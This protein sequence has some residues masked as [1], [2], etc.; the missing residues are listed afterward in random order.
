MIAQPKI[1]ECEQNT[2][3]WLGERTKYMGSSDAPIALGYSSFKSPVDLA[4]EKKI[5]RTSNHHPEPETKQQ[6]RGH[7]LEPLTGEIYSMQTGALL[8]PGKSYIHPNGIMAASLDFETFDYTSIVE[9][10]THYSYQSGNYPESG[11]PDGVSNYE[12]I[13]C[14]HQ[15]YVAG[16]YEMDC[17]VLFGDEKTFDL[18]VKMLDEGAGVRNV[19]GMCLDIGM[20]FRIYPIIRNEALIETMVEMEIEFWNKYVLGDEIPCD[21]RYMEPVNGLRT[22]TD[23]EEK[24]IELLKTEWLIHS[25][26]KS[27]I[28]R[29]KDELKMSIKDSEGLESAHGKITYRKPKSNQKTNWQKAAERCF[30]S[31]TTSEREEILKECEEI[32]DLSRRLNLPVSMW[33]KDL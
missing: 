7:S 33:K 32:P 8:I 14:H 22:A 26:A 25:M 19:A 18:L 4:Q 9:A 31:M 24:M 17:A 5:A 12:M 27:E 16:R 30:E 13:Q 1:M 23:A 3:E 10:K 6:H 20:D 11:T 21:I 29:L 15:M 2:P 28:D